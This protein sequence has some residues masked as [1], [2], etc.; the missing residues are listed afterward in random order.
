MER[1]EI[2]LED[3]RIDSSP[4]VIDVA[5]EVYHVL[6]SVIQIRVLGIASIGN[7]HG[8]SFLEPS[9]VL[10]FIKLTESSQMMTLMRPIEC[11]ARWNV[12]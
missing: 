7:C 9:M 4:V 3:V 5:D 10:P 6:I 2:G 1:V 11:R 8:A 12:L